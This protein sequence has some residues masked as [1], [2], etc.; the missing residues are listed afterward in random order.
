MSK[1]A[2]EAR[3]RKNLADAALAEHELAVQQGS[4]VKRDIVYI[5]WAEIAGNAHARL[6][7]LGSKL[8]PIL[9][10]LETIPQIRA[11]ID[12]AVREIL[13]ELD[14]FQLPDEQPRKGRRGPRVIKTRRLSLGKD[15]VN[16]GRTQVATSPASNGQR[17]GGS[18]T[19][20]IPRVRL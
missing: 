18:K 12:K 1:A 4:V 17:M 8:A 7:P 5:A 3:T 16:G 20:S 10:G 9:L 11:V 13:L 2:D 6:L 19:G 14:Q 15:A